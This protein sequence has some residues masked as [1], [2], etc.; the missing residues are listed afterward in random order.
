V[1]RADVTKEIVDADPAVNTGSLKFE[2]KKLYIA[3][4]SF[5][6]K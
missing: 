4:G 1:L 5:C 6:E 3:K 2:M